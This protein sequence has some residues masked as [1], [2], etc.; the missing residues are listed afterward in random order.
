MCLSKT[1]LGIFLGFVLP[2]FHI[3]II[4]QFSTSLSHQEQQSRV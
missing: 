3:L 1:F 2:L 4:H